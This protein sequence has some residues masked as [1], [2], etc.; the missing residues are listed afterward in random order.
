MKTR[1]ATGD[2]MK[3][4]IS[5]SLAF[6]R[7]KKPINCEHFLKRLGGIVYWQR[8]CKRIAAHYSKVGQWCLPTPLKTILRIY[9]LQR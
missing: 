7:T 2:A 5:A 6:G 4:S 1:S 9:C 3:Q 8:L